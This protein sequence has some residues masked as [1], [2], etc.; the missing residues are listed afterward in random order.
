[1]FLISEVSFRAVDAKERSTGHLKLA[2][3]V[4][5]LRGKCQLSMALLAR[6]SNFEE[7]KGRSIS[8]Q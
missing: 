8:S 6:A 5:H 1:M 4:L 7:N 2:R 3:R